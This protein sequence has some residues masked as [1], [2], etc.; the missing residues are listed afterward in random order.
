VAGQDHEDAQIVGFVLAGQ[1]NAFRILIERHE[2][3][4]LAMGMSFFH[5][6]DSARDFAQD[7]FI[8]AFNNLKSFEG[9]SAFSTWIFRIG[10]NQA[11]N[12]KNRE[13]EYVSLAD[14]ED[15]AGGYA[16]RADETPEVEHLKTVIK[17]AVREAVKELPEKYRIC[18]DLS[19][20]YDKTYDEIENI[21]GIPVNTIKSHVL[22]AKKILRDKL[23]DYR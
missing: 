8:K 12:T 23:G 1:T 22:R 11:I 7:V 9:R 5:N 10:Y 6:I 4:V 14:D 19:F 16:A 13:K 15:G 20:F 17:G 18:I 2:K 3:K 21:T